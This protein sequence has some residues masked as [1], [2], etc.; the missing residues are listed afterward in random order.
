MPARLA[1]GEF[2]NRRDFTTV[3]LLTIDPEDARD[4]DDAVFAER[5]ND[6]YRVWV[7]I[8][9]VSEYVQSSSALD[10]EALTRGCTIYL[11]DRAIPM[12]PAALAA[13]VCSLLPDVERLC[14]CVTADLDAHG[15]VTSFEVA[16]G[17]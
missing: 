5:R 15:N 17:R 9:D 14:M 1:R 7:A 12:L 3:P 8:A 4:H 16:D 2:A 10:A 13:D 6:G 11:P